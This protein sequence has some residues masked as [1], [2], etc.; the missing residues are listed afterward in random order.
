MTLRIN[1]SDDILINGKQTEFKAVQ[2]PQKTVVYRPECLFTGQKYE[3]INM[4]QNRYSLCCENPVSG[5]PGVA[6]FERDLLA[7]IKNS[8]GD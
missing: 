1:T 4:P 2:T 7:A 6:Q 8:D 5:M 3:E